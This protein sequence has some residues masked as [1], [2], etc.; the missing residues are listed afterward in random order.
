[1]TCP[2][3]EH[4]EKEEISPNK[5]QHRTGKTM[6][7]EHFLF[8]LI[9]FRLLSRQYVSISRMLHPVHDHC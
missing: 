1:M 2:H 4:G 3:H 7:T 8:R 9:F 5:L 6:N